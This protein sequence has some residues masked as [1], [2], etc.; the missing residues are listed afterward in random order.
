MEKLSN[1]LVDMRER[2]E[3]NRQQIRSCSQSSD[4]L[5]DVSMVCVFVHILI[6]FSVKDQL[7]CVLKLVFV[8]AK[9][10]V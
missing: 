2:Y 8:I 4:P 5:H 7:V 6:L 1:R 3:V 9:S 10:S